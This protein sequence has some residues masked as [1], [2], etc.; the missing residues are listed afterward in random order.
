[1]IRA[2]KPPWWAVA[3]SAGAL[4]ALVGGWT[5]AE[6]LQGGSYNPVRMT[7]SSLA[8]HGAEHRWVM[9]GALIAIGV[10]HLVTALGLCGTRIGARLV[11]AAAGIAG[12]G[13]GFFAQ[14]E[15]GSANAHLAFAALGL[16]TLA[17]WPLT[18]A[19]ASATRFPL[20][21]RDAAWSGAL[22][23]VLLVWLALSISGTTLGLAERAITF[24]QELWPL[25]VVVALRLPPRPAA[26]VGR[27]SSW[28]GW[29]I[30][31]ADVRHPVRTR[32]A[33]TS[34]ANLIDRSRS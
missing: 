8:R 34:E 33:A 20:R 19:T 27:R 2:E 3:S 21:P 24:Q 28:S 4:I 5:T 10:C 16:V 18:V 7:I 30:T 25:L 11:L 14:P 32:A 29:R 13:L 17:V 26:E 12:L 31:F 15:H 9:T 23:V 22:S 1:M 6:A